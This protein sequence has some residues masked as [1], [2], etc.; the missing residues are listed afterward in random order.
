MQKEQDKEQFGGH[1]NEAFADLDEY[2]FTLKRRDTSGDITFRTADSKPSEENTLDSFNDLNAFGNI[3]TAHVVETYEINLEIS[4][5]KET[6][7]KMKVVY[8]VNRPMIDEKRASKGKDKINE[9]RKDEIK[10]D[11]RESKRDVTSDS[12][13]S[14]D[15]KYSMD[16]DELYKEIHLPEKQ[17]PVKKSKK[18]EKKKENKKKEADVVDINAE[19]PFVRSFRPSSATVAPQPENASGDH[20][21]KKNQSGEAKNHVTDRNQSDLPQVH[22]SSN[23]FVPR[24]RNNNG[25]VAV[26]YNPNN[27]NIDIANLDDDLV[28]ITGSPANQIFQ[29]NVPKL[30]AHR[31]AILGG[32]QYRSS[33]YKRGNPV[34][35]RII[36]NSLRESK[37]LQKIQMEEIRRIMHP[38][39]DIV[40]PWAKNKSEDKTL[41]YMLIGVLIFLALAA[42]CVPLLWK[43]CEYFPPLRLSETLPNLLHPVLSRSSLCVPYCILLMYYL[44][45]FL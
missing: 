12:K 23:G 1:F 17:R 11:L 41:K 4:E 28:P 36:R 33:K 13:T 27:V 39:Q 21:T 31:L 26:L 16:L 3:T 20:M 7:E 15:S 2:G 37:E 38:T 9:E 34:E 35:R 30:S 32:S 40:P 18:K 25:N 43:F 29:S 45:I 8:E 24:E 6:G 42:I 44:I 22:R 19:S 14:V 5:D 10:E